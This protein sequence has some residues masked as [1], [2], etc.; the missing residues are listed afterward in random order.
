MLGSVMKHAR[1]TAESR[2]RRKRTPSEIAAA[3]APANLW[4]VLTALRMFPG[5]HSADV[6]RVCGV[7]RRYVASAIT[8]G[9]RY[10]LIAGITAKLYLTERG[11]IVL[12]IFCG[13]EQKKNTEDRATPSRPGR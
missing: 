13:I 3:M 8:L 5:L 2:Q 12:A 6:Y 7:N 9:R 4:L 11:K 1:S 10:D